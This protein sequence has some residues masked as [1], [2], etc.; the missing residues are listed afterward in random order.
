MDPVYKAELELSRKTRFG[1]SMSRLGILPLSPGGPGPIKGGVSMSVPKYKVGEKFQSAMTVRE[2]LAVSVTSGGEVKYWVDDDGDRDP[3]T[4][5][6][7]QVDPWRK[8]EPFFE[9][10]KTY[11][12]TNGATKYKVTDIREVDGEKFAWAEENTFGHLSMTTLDEH[13]FRQMTEV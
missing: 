8:I 1:G 10:R 4:V 7:S 6:E 9:I 13:N 11:R 3:F 2:I 5:T 12:F